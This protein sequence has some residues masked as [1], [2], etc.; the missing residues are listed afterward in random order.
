MGPLDEFERLVQVSKRPIMVCGPSGVGKSLF[1]HV[2]NKIKQIEAKKEKRGWKKPR[3]LNCAAFNEQLILSE[4]FG[5]K[6][7]SFTGAGSDR[8]GHIKKADG[9]ILILEEVGELAPTVQAQLLT[10]LEDGYFYRVGSNERESANVTIIGTTNRMNIAEKDFRRDFWFR[11]T[12]FN[13]PGLHQRRGDILYLL[14]S[15]I[16][17]ILPKLRPWEVLNFLS[18]N[19]PGNVR[20]ILDVATNIEKE[21]LREFD[22][23]IKVSHFQESVSYHNFIGEHF[24]GLDPLNFIDF[25]NDLNL[26]DREHLQADLSEYRLGL[27][28]DTTDLAFPDFR[29]N[30]IEKELLIPDPKNP[31]NRLP[32][33]KS[34]RMVE[35][36]YNIIDFFG[37]D[38]FEEVEDGLFWKFAHSRGISS[39]IDESLLVAKREQVPEI[40]PEKRETDISD[41]DR[42]RD[43]V[44]RLP[45]DEVERLWFE[46]RFRKYKG[47]ISKFARDAEVSKNK[48]GKRIEKYN[49]RGF[50]KG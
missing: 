4:L 17:E 42:L 10:F 28:V 23:P 32:F 26:I 48:I 49:L 14:A 37:V 27:D 22:I 50:L 7:G 38:A 44:T 6:K 1:I 9:G 35:E 46:G 20:E 24:K 29:Y 33:S 30:K 21:M 11:F 16:P 31:K 18:Y 13:V 25:V 34:R 36:T 5:H 40:A 39:F 2:F 41:Q 43:A 47:N 12:R 19:W 15:Y 8:V 45:F 3:T